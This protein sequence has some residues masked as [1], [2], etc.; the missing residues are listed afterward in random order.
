MEKKS[1]EELIALYRKGSSEALNTLITSNIKLVA[2]IV[3]KYDNCENIANDELVSVGLY[4]LYMAVL[5]FDSTLNIKFSTYASRKMQGYI[6]KYINNNKESI[7]LKDTWDKLYKGISDYITKYEARYGKTPSDEDIMQVFNIDKYTLSRLQN[8]ALGLVR[9]DKIDEMYKTS[10]VDIDE[11]FDN[12]DM[13]DLLY[14]SIDELP[15]KDRYILIDSYGLF[16]RDKMLRVDV[17]K[18]YNLSEAS[19]THS[20]NRSREYLKRKFKNSGYVIK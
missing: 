8:Y 15:K 13:L 17:A 19:I 12:K 5:S 18:K 16:D 9:L 6:L 20:L 4:A 3:K 14:E 10:A 7:I 11:Y 1:N 2:Y